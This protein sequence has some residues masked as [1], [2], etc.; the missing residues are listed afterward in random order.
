[1]IRGFV[2]LKLTQSLPGIYQL[3]RRE[4]N[5]RRQTHGLLVYGPAGCFGSNSRS[6][7]GCGLELPFFNLSYHLQPI[8]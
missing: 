6:A 2:V 1:M 8:S 5:R 3:A 4:G 7:K